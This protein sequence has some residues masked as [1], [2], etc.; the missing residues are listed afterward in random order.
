MSAIALAV[1]S[2]LAGAWFRD[3]RATSN[4]A[5]RLDS[6]ASK[7]KGESGEL[8]DMDRR[9]ELA[10][11][12][13]K[14]GTWELKLENE[15]RGTAYWNAYFAQQHGYE[16]KGRE[17]NSEEFYAAIQPAC[18]V[19]VE[20]M[21]LE[22][23]SG[24]SDHFVAVYQT[25]EGRWIELNA[26]ILSW[27]TEGHPQ[28]VFGT[29]LDVTVQKNAD[30]L[31]V[32]AFQ[33]LVAA[34]EAMNAAF[35]MFDEHDK[36][37]VC[38]QQYADFFGAQ[39]S[40]LVPGQSY[41]QILEAM[42]EAGPSPLAP[43]QT[44][45]HWLQEQLENHKQYKTDILVK[46]GQRW[47][48][49]SHLR[50]EEGGKVIL[51]Y[52]VTTIKNL[53]AAL[54]DAKEE[55]ERSNKAK[56][57]F[58]AK[59]S[60]E[61]RTPLNAILGFT[62]VLER[63]ASLSKE[64]RRYISSIGSSGE[65]LLGLINDVLEMS[66][67][68]SGKM[69]LQSEVF[70]LCLL[71]KG[72][73][74]LFQL[75]A[76][77]GGNRFV[78]HLGELQCPYF[79]ESDQKKIRQILSNLVSNAL[80]FTRVG[81]VDVY[82]VVIETSDTPPGAQLCFRVVDTGAGVEA[83]HVEKI[84]MP[85]EQTLVGERQSEGT[86][87]GLSICQEFAKLLGGRIEVTSAPGK[88]AEFAFSVPVVLS[89]SQQHGREAFSVR[90]IL[91]L[92]SKDAGKRVLIVDDYPDNRLIL[93]LQ[94][95]RVGFK[96]FEAGDGLESVAM[97]ERYLPE[98]VLMDVIMPRMGGAEAIRR[99]RA[100]PGGLEAKII[101]IS[102]SVLNEHMK[103][104]KAAGTDEFLLKPTREWLLLEHI[105]CLL[106]V[107]YEYGSEQPSV[108]IIH[109]VN[110]LEEGEVL[111][112]RLISQVLEACNTLDPQTM[113]ACIA[114]LGSAHPKVSAALAAYLDEYDWNG[115]REMISQIKLAALE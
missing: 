101:S 107:E 44:A 79:I 13:A 22:F 59:M 48:L 97:F 4:R 58:L 14:L 1:I 16:E 51:R 53:E 41:H 45:E 61:I 28:R 27:D 94:L 49:E 81:S 31:N 47:F 34:V 8:S 12:V 43:G 96:V 56:S 76:E 40:V 9:Y 21:F 52:D 109:D 68:E 84:F 2:F 115:I 88:G 18:R 6:S 54:R 70:D 26:R 46:G 105:G 15:Q 30:L 114:K 82:T 85:F 36:F 95:E 74:E 103:E 65:N 87:L 60:H 72:V 62:Q 89:G 108:E 38:N 86:G 32:R 80:K 55:A 17:A 104:L 10:V 77:A 29:S 50:T 91:H 64:V 69:E 24:E 98:L 11:E 66:K 5:L 83:A 33:R 100:L 106:G 75:R 73:E 92:N 3:W 39:S 57:A 67:I 113:E 35:V 93:K 23:V 111:D 25:L 112:E 90:P 71:L 37:I 99:I 7:A 78:I 110:L 20:K 102:A 63:Q 42:L 19:S